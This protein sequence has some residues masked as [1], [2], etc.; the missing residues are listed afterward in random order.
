MNICWRPHLFSFLHLATREINW[1]REKINKPNG[2][3][4]CNYIHTIHHRLT[5]PTSSQSWMNG[6]LKLISFDQFQLGWSSSCPH[7]IQLRLIILVWKHL[8]V[9]IYVTSPPSADLNFLKYFTGKGTPQYLNGQHLACELWAGMCEVLTKSGLT[10][11]WNSFF[12]HNGATIL[13]FLA[14]PEGCIHNLEFISF[15]SV[16][17]HASLFWD[18]NPEMTNTRKSPTLK[19]ITRNGLFTFSSPRDKPILK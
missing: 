11:I 7:Y 14:G 9:N 18:V 2:D 10:R 8:N 1:N 17:C 16:A 12:L 15:N 5:R 6:W 13:S 4:W 3:G 19:Q